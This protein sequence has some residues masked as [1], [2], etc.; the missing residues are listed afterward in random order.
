MV[1]RPRVEVPPQ[2]R[3]SIVDAYVTRELTLRQTSGEVGYSRRVVH[4]VLVEE[5]VTLREGGP[6]LQDRGRPTKVR[7]E[8]I[9]AMVERWERGRSPA[10]IALSLDLSP[11]TVRVYLRKHSDYPAKPIT[12]VQP[13]RPEWSTA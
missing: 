1:G 3:R 5:G 4:R 6:R 8:M 13:Y 12:A 11:P 10:Q 9:A 2:V 7:P